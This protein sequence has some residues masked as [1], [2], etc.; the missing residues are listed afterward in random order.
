[1]PAAA[2]A[3]QGCA[4]GFVARIVV[5]KKRRN[6]ASSRLASFAQGMKDRRVYR[7][8]LDAR[9]AAACVKIQ[10]LWRGALARARLDEAA[11]FIKAGPG[12]PPQQA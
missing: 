8:M 2:A 4:R 3:I 1:M 7:R 10:P 6:L 12:P 9:Y 11:G 5:R